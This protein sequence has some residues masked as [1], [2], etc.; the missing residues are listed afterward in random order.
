MPPAPAVNTETASALR[1]LRRLLRPLLLRAARLDRH[2]APGDDQLP[3]RLAD[4]L[5]LERR[6]LL[7]AGGL[8]LIRPAQ[9]RLTQQLLR[10]ARVGA[11][12]RPH[13]RQVALDA[14]RDL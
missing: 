10:D 14:L 1:L 8:E 13:S 4:V 5:R 9:A 12:L 7:L 11:A 3:Q 6:D 2:Q